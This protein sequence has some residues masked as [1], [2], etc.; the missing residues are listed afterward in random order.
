MPVESDADIL[1]MFDAEEFGVAA[2]WYPGW[3]RNWPRS[4]EI[5]MQAGTYALFVEGTDLA[6][7]RDNPA[8]EIAGFGAG[9]VATAVHVIL[10]AAA[11]PAPP[12]RKDVITIAAA[13]YAVETPTH[14][15]DRALIFLTLS[16][17]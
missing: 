5:D 9:S 14:D 6:L 15:V 12:L 16:G 7:I 13:S 4:L 10:P 11:L 3:G 8:A 1:G 17:S 2:T